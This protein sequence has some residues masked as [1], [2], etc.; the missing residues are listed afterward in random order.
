MTLDI[1]KV[2]LDAPAFGEGSQADTSEKDTAD[3]SQ[4]QSVE[5]R[6]SSTSGDRPD[7]SEEED[8]DEQRVPYSRFEAAQRRAKEAERNEA[9]SRQRYEELVRD[10]HERELRR[11]DSGHYKGDLPS[12]WVKM[13]GDTEV[14]REAYQYELE[15]QSSIRTEARRAAVEAAQE[16]REN[17]FRALAENESTID[18]R[19]ENLSEGLGRNLSEKEESA[20]LDII[21]EYTPKDANGNYVGGELIPFEKAWEIYQ[22]KQSSTSERSRNSRRTPTSLTSSRTQGEPSADKKRA[23]AEFNPRDWNSWKKRIPN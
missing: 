6:D 3:V 2:D 5:E 16:S 7:V 14:S 20:L 23:D 21:D 17:E 1:S 15:R 13:Y 8:K 4:T 18:N 22:L 12:Y 9:E 10:R 11:E 19:L